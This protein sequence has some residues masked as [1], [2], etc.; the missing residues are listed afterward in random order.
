M[1]FLRKP[2]I[3]STRNKQ[4]F[5][6]PEF[7]NSGCA[8][9]IRSTIDRA[10]IIPNHTVII[11]VTTSPSRLDNLLK[12][13]KYHIDIGT[14]PASVNLHI[15]IPWIFERT[16]EKFPIIISPHPQIL[17]HYGVVDDGPATKLL[18]AIEY[19]QR[20]NKTRIVITV[21]DDTIYS[22]G[23]VEAHWL[24]F[25][26][27]GYSVSTVTRPSIDF[28][29]PKCVRAIRESAV[30][31]VAKTSDTVDGSF[32]EGF[33]TVAYPSH[34]IDVID[35]RRLLSYGE[36]ACYKSDDWA[37][38]ASLIQNRIGIVWLNIYDHTCTSSMLKQLDYGFLKDALHKQQDHVNTYERCCF[39]AYKEITK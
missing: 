31:N 33:T 12:T 20:T 34:L 28:M 39:L 26:S 10:G 13:T 21:D 5:G 23:L 2:A 7:R 25:R 24:S 3:K 4:L 29:G 6:I 32:V 22:R 16:G 35:I 11:S 1:V 14:I 17:L 18:G 9:A 30:R 36:K 15:Q 37:I 38:S 19:L 27:N 8:D